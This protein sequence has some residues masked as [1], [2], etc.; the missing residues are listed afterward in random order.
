[1][2]KIEISNS[3]IEKER[4]K[5]CSKNVKFDVPKENQA[6][7]FCY[8]NEIEGERGDGWNGE[9]MNDMKVKESLTHSEPRP[10]PLNC[11]SSSG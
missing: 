8:E 9:R 11:Q 3:Q 2:V 10:G 7:S 6:K 5:F 1:M 4:C